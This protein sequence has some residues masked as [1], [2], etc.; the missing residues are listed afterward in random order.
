MDKN[1]FPVTEEDK[2]ASVLL[3]HQRKH[4]TV[5]NVQIVSAF[6]HKS[7]PQSLKAL[8]SAIYFTKCR[9]RKN[10]LLTEFCSLQSLHPTHAVRDNRKR[11]WI[12]LRWHEPVPLC[13]LSLTL[14]VGV[15]TY[16]ARLSQTNCTR[17][18]DID[19]CS[20]HWHLM[21]YCEP[22]VNNKWRQKTIIVGVCECVDVRY[23]VPSW[24]SSF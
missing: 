12:I 10:H 7:S 17:H 21:K 13:L 16:L 1:I 20:V 18:E 14:S 11:D 9:I 6:L 3:F 22:S 19:S 2:I 8:K 23:I 15:L 24:Q 4:Q 5:V